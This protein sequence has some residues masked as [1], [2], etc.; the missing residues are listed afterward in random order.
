[1]PINGTYSTP[2]TQ[3]N[4]YSTVDDLL[5]LLYDNTSNAIDARD[6]RDSVYTLWDK[7]DNI[8]VAGNGVTASGT[9]NYLAKFNDLN[10]L[11]NSTITD[12]GST[13]TING[14]LMVL[15]TTST[16]DTLNLIVQDPIFL[17]AGTQSGTPLL[18]SGFFIDRGTGMTAGIIW[19]ESEDEFSFIQTN[20]PATIYGDVNI[21]NYSNIR[22]ASASLT[23]LYLYGTSSG[24][25]KLE[26]SNQGSSKILMSDA[27][28]IGTWQSPALIASYSY[29]KE[30]VPVSEYVFVPSTSQYWVYGDLNI[31]GTLENKGHVIVVNGDCIISGS[32]SNSGTYSNL[33]MAEMSGPG[34]ANYIPKWESD[35]ILS[36]TSSIMDSGDIVTITAGTTSIPNLY[37]SGSSSGIFRLEDTTQ[38]NG[39]ILTS[40]SNGVG[41]W[42]PPVSG[43][44]K[45]TAT[46]SFDAGITYSILHGLN[47][48]S[49]L[50][51]FWDSDSGELMVVGVKKGGTY[52]GT[53]SLNYIDVNS[54]VYISNGEIV[55]MS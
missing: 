28:G 18:D 22:G 9:V 36:T 37:I 26:D 30:T 41:T 27:N 6:V 25:F 12:D 13:V 10:I 33:Y 14:D 3:A 46:Q 43:V 48:T 52:G 5:G 35:H 51:N 1:M 31:D 39:Y 20:D 44:S 7:I 23:G 17:L 47:S 34:I 50:Y 54:S 8:H 53:Y 24:I 11:G 29:I 49:I 15:G 4:S 21:N 19:D 40:D 45:F 2:P 55:I 42:S 16:I 38:S 32:F